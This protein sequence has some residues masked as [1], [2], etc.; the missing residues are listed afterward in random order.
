MKERSGWSWDLCTFKRPQER[1]HL[2]RR[3]RQ[4]AQPAGQTHQDGFEVALQE[5]SERCE[6]V[7]GGTLDQLPLRPA[8][9]LLR[10]AAFYQSIP[11]KVQRRVNKCGSSTTPGGRGA[12]ASTEALLQGC[13]KVA[14][15]PKK[16]VGNPLYYF[17]LTLQTP[18]DTYRQSTVVQR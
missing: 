13:P 14:R 7:D 9:L 1:D 15:K 5:V 17:R 3:V 2:E 16:S 12:A 11:W 6:E 4:A 18:A 8:D 10:L